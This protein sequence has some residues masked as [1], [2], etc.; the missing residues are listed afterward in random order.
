MLLELVELSCF[1]SWGNYSQQPSNE[2]GKSSHSETCV[3][4]DGLH[5]LFLLLFLSPFFP[6]SPPPRPLPLL[7]PS[8]S[9]SSPFCCYHVCPQRNAVL[10]RACL[11][12]SRMYSPCWMF[13]SFLRAQLCCFDRLL[14]GSV[15]I[16]SRWSLDDYWP[17]S[18]SCWAITWRFRLPI[19]SS[20]FNIS[21]HE[22][23]PFPD[24]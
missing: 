24:R 16:L 20:I 6:L 17:I 21:R 2:R 18:Q 12:V 19:L 11:I 22:R 8:T 9:D 5:L 10:M 4:A 13:P 14:T 15:H 3:G 23:L 7:P 1:I